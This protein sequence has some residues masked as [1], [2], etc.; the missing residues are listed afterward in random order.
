M[1]TVFADTHYWV[2]LIHKDDE[3]HELARTK[4]SEL[5]P[6]KII[7]TQMVLVEF[8]N[9][10]TARLGLAYK[11]P[12]VELVDNIIADPNTGAATQ[13]VDEND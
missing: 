6:L 8:L 3:H 10:V 1:K 12:A 11:A 5:R 9:Y 13:G 7:T 4:P 2:A